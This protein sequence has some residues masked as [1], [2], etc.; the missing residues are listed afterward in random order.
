MRKTAPFSPEYRRF[1]AL[2]KTARRTAGL[3]Q[4]D[5]AKHLGRPQSYVSKYELGE[6]RLDVIEFVRITKAL[7]A[8]PCAIIQRIKA[9]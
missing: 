3:T 8:D 1:C 7:S 4:N 2:L 5:V 9:S 6:R